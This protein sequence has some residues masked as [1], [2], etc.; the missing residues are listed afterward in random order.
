MFVHTHRYAFKSTFTV[1][2]PTASILHVYVHIYVYFYGCVYSNKYEE[3]V[4]EREER[5]TGVF[6]YAFHSDDFHLSH[7]YFAFSHISTAEI[8][9]YRLHRSGYLKRN[10]GQTLKPLIKHFNTFVCQRKIKF[11]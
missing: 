8:R 11:N 9:V 10:S 7:Y 2:V 3:R 6:M 5:L 4:R 1:Y